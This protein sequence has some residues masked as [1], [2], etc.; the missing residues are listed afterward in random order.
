VNLAFLEKGAICLSNIAIL[1]AIYASFKPL[2]L[3]SCS[4]FLSDEL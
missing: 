1:I 2:S 3:H 4:Y